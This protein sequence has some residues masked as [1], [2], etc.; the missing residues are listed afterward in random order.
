VDD[1]LAGDLAPS[2]RAT[3]AKASTPAQAIALL[4]GSPE[5]QKR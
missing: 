3:V 4:L 1:I 5:F 2:T